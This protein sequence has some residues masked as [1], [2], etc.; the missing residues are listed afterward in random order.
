[1]D[2]AA[3]LFPARGRN[4]A[5]ASVFGGRLASCRGLLRVLRLGKAEH[6][7]RAD[8]VIF[9]QRAQ[10]ADGHFVDAVFIAGVDLLRR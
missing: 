6:I 4:A 8:A 7:I 1:M 9:A 10:V 5:A 2:A 3:A